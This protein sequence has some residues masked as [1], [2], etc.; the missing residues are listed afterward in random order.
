LGL[1]ALLALICI[2]ALAV[3]L[4]VGLKKHSSTQTKS[5]AG[6]S[7]S[8]SNDNSASS[9]TS[10]PASGGSGTSETSGT[11]GGGE[12]GNNNSTTSTFPIGTYSFDTFLNTVSTSC[13]SNSATWLCYPYSTYAESP[14][15]SSTIFNWIIAPTIPASKN[16]TISSTDNPFSIVFSNLTLHLMKE[17]ASDEHYFFQT[18]M[19]KPT[20]PTTQLG[21]NNV[22]STCYFNSTTFQGYL[23]TKMAKSYPASEAK[24][25]SVPYQ[26]W[27]Y[28]VKIEQVA[29]AGA[30]T[31]N[32]IDSSGNSLGDFSVS[33]GTQLCDCLY[34]NYGT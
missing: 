18:M 32:C 10:S 29:A 6:G 34:L 11:S 3:G 1:I 31:P 21:S 12:S 33:D 28:A 19:S 27:P 17:G 8:N 22:A 26:A 25:P 9:G 2:I 20:K 13:T 16:Y 5:V 15:S 24:S 7:S 23:Y 14:S 4:G 30:D